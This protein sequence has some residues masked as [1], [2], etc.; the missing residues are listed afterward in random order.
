VVSDAVREKLEARQRAAQQAEEAAPLSEVQ[1]GVMKGQMAALME[2]AETVMQ[3]LKRLGAGQ[4]GA[5]GE[6]RGGRRQLCR[7]RPCP[8]CAPPPMPS[9]P[10]PPPAPRR[11]CP[12]P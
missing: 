9:P 6:P 5:K 4:A 1:V 3:A 10:A 12:Q 2:E 7:A 11:P 8:G